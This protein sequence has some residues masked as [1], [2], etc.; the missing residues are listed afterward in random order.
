MD[1][2]H[3][4]EWPQI[5]ANVRAHES[6]QLDLALATAEDGYPVH[7]VGGSDGKKKPLTLHGFKDATTEAPQIITW[8]NR[9]HYALVSIPTGEKSGLVVLDIDIGGETWLQKLL[10]REGLETEDDLTSVWAVTPSGGRHY[11]FAFEDGTYPRTRAGDIAPNVDSRG[12]GGGII[13]PGNVAT[14][15]SYV[16]GGR[17]RFGD[18][19][20]MPIGLLYEMTF[21]KKQRLEI[22]NS[23]EIKEAIRYSNPAQ[24]LATFE[25][26]QSAEQERIRARLQHLPEDGEGMRHQGLHDTAIAAAEY[27]GLEDG[28]HTQ[29]FLKACCVGKYVAHGLL[30]ENEFRMPFLDAARANWALQHY[31]RTWADKELRRALMRSQNDPLPPLAREFRTKGDAA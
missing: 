27:A 29:L 18:E 14:R 2:S 13:I 12:I 25:A 7:P 15:G 30:S 4:P 23:P 11:Y 16:W 8:W 1:L 10:V 21:S 24:W 26:H 9:W 22:R 19:Q 6:G 28:R 20:P 5:V 31:G 17:G 3:H